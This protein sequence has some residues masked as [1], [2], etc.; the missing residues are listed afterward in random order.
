MCDHTLGERGEGTALQ[1]IC[2][3]FMFKELI[4]RDRVTAVSPA[5]HH[6]VTRLTPYISGHVLTPHCKETN[7]HESGQAK[8]VP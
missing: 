7:S 4:I 6:R 5:C 8:R 2:Q 1:L 3:A